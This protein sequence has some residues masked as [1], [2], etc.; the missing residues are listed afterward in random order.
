[1]AKK[2]VSKKVAQSPSP[3]MMIVAVRASVGVTLNMGDYE[4]LRLEASLTAEVAG[5]ESAVPAAH[6]HLTE[7]CVVQL[8]QDYDGLTW[9]LVTK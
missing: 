8:Q 2:T 3:D 4:S 7:L 6:V 9:P 5:G 1:M